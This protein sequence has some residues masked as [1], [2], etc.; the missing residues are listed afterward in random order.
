MLRPTSFCLLLTL[1]IFVQAQSITLQP[2][3]ETDTTL[4]TPESVLFYP[5][6]QVLY[7]SCVNGPANLANN[8]SYIAKV[9]L[10]GKV[11][12]LKFVDGLNATKGMG[13]LGN[14]LYVTEMTQVA[15][16]DLAT[17]TILN[18][19]PIEGATF[20]N[21]ISV[22]TRKNIIYVTDSKESNVWALANGKPR[23]IATGGPLQGSN[24]LRIDNNQVLIGN[25]DGSLLS[26]DPET[27]QLRTIARVVSTTSID[28]IVVLGNGMYLIN[29]VAGKI[30]YVRANGTP[31]LKLDTSSQQINSADTDYNPAT[32]VLFVP[33]L[34]HNTVRAY[35]V[36]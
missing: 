14:K 17:G 28:G 29:E 27:K 5:A 21:D 1:P 7:V 15:E 11:L 25:G 2:I 26:L 18:R 6:Q 20:L 22:D 10:D 8:S 12:Q 30:W 36:R 4:R 23:L 32:K 13:I 16:I 24:G 19:Y 9:G 34:F 31:E 33:T 35:S 3:W